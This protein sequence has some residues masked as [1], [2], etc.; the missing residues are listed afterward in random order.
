M[1]QNTVIIIGIVIVLLAG[2]AYYATTVD[3]TSQT[4]TSTPTGVNT[5]EFTP[6]APVATTDSLAVP[7]DT[8]AVV[9]G[10]ITPNGALTS[11]WY[12]YG[13]SAS[14]GSKTTTQNLGSGYTSIPSPAFIAGLTKDTTY[15][16]RVVA[17]NQHG[18]TAGTIRT[19]VTTHDNPAP[20]GSAPTTKTLAA[21]DIT[22]MTANLSGE[23]TPN[24]A[25]TQYWF[26]YGTTAALGNTTPFVPVGD[27]VAKV[28]ASQSL[29]NLQ[30][31]TTYHF[32]INTQNQFGTV[33][34]SILTFRTLGPQA[35]S[36]PGAN[37]G[38]ATVVTGTS[39]TLRGT[40]TPNG[41]AVTYWFEY[42]TD[43]NFVASLLNETAHLPAAGTQ[44]TATVSAPVTGLTPNTTYYARLIVQNATG[45]V[46]GDRITFKTK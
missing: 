22:R 23:V 21:S 29:S 36:A 9:T 45:V 42:S 15:H 17:S 33:N 7:S 37:T 28:P 46:R 38:S 11:Y 8:A 30:P 35:A 25:A 40:V 24:S 32:R 13:T 39:A 27:G 2:L 41:A 43:A 44:S 20:V 3:T 4:A 18:D 1:N 19:F 31:L 10:S 5:E 16:S 26:E 6:G 12:E 34:G 14:L